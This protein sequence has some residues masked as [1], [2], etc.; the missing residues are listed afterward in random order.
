MCYIDFRVMT[1]AIIPCWFVLDYSKIKLE[2][3]SSTNWIFNLEKLIAKL[4]SAGYRGSKNPVWNKLKIQ[5]NKLD[6]SNLI[7]KKSSTDG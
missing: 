6:F 1:I 4:I 5:F 2:K 3:S 7:F